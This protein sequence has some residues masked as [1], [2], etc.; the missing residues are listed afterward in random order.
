MQGPPLDRKGP[1]PRPH[2]AST[3][4]GMLGWAAPLCTAALPML[5]RTLRVDGTCKLM[6]FAKLAAA[7]EDLPAAAWSP[8]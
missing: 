7:A 3:L 1:C 6:V 8:G 5:E 2:A 4:C